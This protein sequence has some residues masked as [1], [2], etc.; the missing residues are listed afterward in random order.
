MALPQH[1]LRS[2]RDVPPREQV[3]CHTVRAIILRHGLGGT[4]F[5]HATIQQAA[6]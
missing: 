1:L 3:P 6:D 2:V 4:T 5:A